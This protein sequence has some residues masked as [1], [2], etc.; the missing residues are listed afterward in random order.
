M[1]K[2]KTKKTD[3]GD[4]LYED[5][6]LFD[7]EANN[8]EELL[9]TLSKVVYNKNFV[10]NSFKDAIIKREKIFP[11][12]LPSPGVKVAIPHTDVE[13]VLTSCITI[14]KL[15]NPIQ[16]IEMGTSSKRLDIELVFM[17]AVNAPKDQLN[18]LQKIMCT[19]SNEKVLLKLKK[20]DT[21]KEIIKI[22]KDQ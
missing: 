4:L 9:T 12:G 1:D 20:A 14:A 17:L 22:I 21:P 2:E 6:V 8:E 16:F 15:K 7:V 5:L 3:I 11:T 19:L 10:K 18:V 13:H